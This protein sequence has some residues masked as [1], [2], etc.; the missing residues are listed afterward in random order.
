MIRRKTTASHPEVARTS[1]SDARKAAH[2]HE[3]GLRPIC[4]GLWRFGSTRYLHGVHGEVHQT[5]ARLAG[6]ERVMLAA[7]KNTSPG[8]SSAAIECAPLWSIETL[9]ELGLAEKC[10]HA[11]AYE[12]EQRIDAARGRERATCA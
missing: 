9:E 2:S 12:A 5:L 4:L 1:S 10:K 11:Q 6:N 8:C 7:L 3:T